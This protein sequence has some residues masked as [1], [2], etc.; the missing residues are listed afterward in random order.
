MSSNIYKN[1]TLFI[2]YSSYFILY[3]NTLALLTKK[4]EEGRKELSEE[5]KTDR[6]TWNSTHPQ[7]LLI[8]TSC[9]T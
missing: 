6:V 1:T 8:V 2:K 4:L 9:Y 3:S 5:F 7:R